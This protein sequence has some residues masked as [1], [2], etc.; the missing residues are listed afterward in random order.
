MRILLVEDDPNNI[1]VAEEQF[2]EHELII[3][4]SYQ[5]FEQKNGCIVARKKEDRVDLILT[6][7][8]IPLG[9]F[10][11]DCITL[12]QNTQPTDL[13]PIGL[14]VLLLARQYNILCFLVSAINHHE[15]AWARILEGS[16]LEANTPTDRLISRDSVNH[17]IRKQFIRYH[18][19]DGSKDW[20]GTIEGNIRCYFLR[21]LGEKELA[22]YL[23]KE[24][25]EEEPGSLSLASKTL[26][27]ELLERWTKL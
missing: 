10:H 7:L 22:D 2:A 25:R 18:D 9:R 16:C 11:E 5:E 21:M 26:Y 15:D 8:Q 24:W 17:N 14:V 20:L 4:K 6:D 3:A 27:F 12:N 1:A 23:W 13:Y 19:G